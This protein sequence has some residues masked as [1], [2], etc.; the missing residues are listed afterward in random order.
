MLK[1]QNAILAL[2]YKSPNAILAHTYKAQILFLT[3]VLHILNPSLVG[4]IIIHP[5]K[6]LLLQDL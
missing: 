3:L 1:V 6:I 2:L 5:S 4:N